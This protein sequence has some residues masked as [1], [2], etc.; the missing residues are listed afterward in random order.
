M[1]KALTSNR[2]WLRLLGD[3]A[4]AVATLLWIAALVYLIRRAE[5]GQLY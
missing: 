5:A 3:A 4:L 2:A 1:L